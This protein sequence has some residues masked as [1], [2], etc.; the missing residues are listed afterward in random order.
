MDIA[1]G[2]G[3]K[4]S[5]AF[6]SDLWILMAE[7]QRFAAVQ[8]TLL[9]TGRLYQAVR[10][11]LLA[12]LILWWTLAICIT[13]DEFQKNQ[14]DWE[15]HLAHHRHHSDSTFRFISSFRSGSVF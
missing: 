6:G 10:S 3:I 15:A 4:S 13:E 8:A 11:A 14:D 2:A 7:D 5:Y 9:K 1:A 12:V